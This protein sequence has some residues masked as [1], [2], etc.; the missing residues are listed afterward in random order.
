MILSIVSAVSGLGGTWLGGYLADRCTNGFRDVRWQLWVPGIATLINVPLAL[1]AY[2]WP[3]RGVVVALLFA[4]LVF[5][6]MYLGPTFATIQRLVTA[7]ERA[8]GAALLLLV[9]NLIGLGLGP[10]LVGMVSDVI[11]QAQL[12]GGADALAAKAQGLQT[13]LAIMVCINV[14]SFAHYMLA[15]R[16][17][18]RDSI[19]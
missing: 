13:A 18:E 7:R 16:S 8:L 5:G 9:I 10:W 2:T 11:Y 14:W 6:V 1:L 3:D 19:N 4:S 17:L 15:A 12:D